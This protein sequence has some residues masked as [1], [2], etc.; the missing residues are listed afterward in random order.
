M[1]RLPEIR[2]TSKRVLLSRV[3]SLL[4]NASS[5]PPIWHAECNGMLP[6]PAS[7]WPRR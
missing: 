2:G 4:L 7:Q 3:Q 5:N 1:K 6:S